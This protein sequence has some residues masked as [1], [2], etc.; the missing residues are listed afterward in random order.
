MKKVTVRKL[1][2][3]VDL[4]VLAGHGGLG[5]EIID[6]EIVLP[7][8]EFAGFLKYFDSRRIVLIGSKE[9]TYLNELERELAYKRVEDICKLKLPAFV[10]SR[11]VMV[12][13]YFLELGDKYNIPILKSELQTTPLN[14]KI[15]GYL[16]SEIANKIT[17][18]YYPEKLWG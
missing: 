12:P 4:L 16:R 1:I 15:F 18:G 5:N 8:L 3:E 11:N 17:T 9:A 13:D 10:F 2:E 6:D 14:G 7:G